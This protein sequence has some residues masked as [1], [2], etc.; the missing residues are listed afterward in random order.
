MLLGPMEGAMAKLGTPEHEHVKR[1]NADGVYAVLVVLWIV[2]VWVVALYIAADAANDTSAGVGGNSFLFGGSLAAAGV[3]T[4]FSLREFWTAY[5]RW[6]G[7]GVDSRNV[8]GTIGEMDM[9]KLGL[10]VALEAKTG[11]EAELAAFLIGAL[12]LVEAEPATTAWFALRMGPT[13][14]GIF[15]AF[16]DEAGRAAHLAGEVAKAL[17]AK[18][19]ELLAKP[20]SIEKIEVLADKLPG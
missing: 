13:S 11:K 7:A 18:A 9:T 1:L 12:P 4:A 20:P 19:P 17:M 2:A 14:F 16:A 10:Y 15:D 5:R 3:V 8:S 6:R